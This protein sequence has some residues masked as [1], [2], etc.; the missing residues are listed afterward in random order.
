MTS[1][2]MNEPVV[3]SKRAHS[4][5]GAP[6]K[7][8]KAAQACLSCRKHKTRCE[9]LDGDNSGAQCHR[10]KVLSLSC[11]FEDGSGPPPGPS[12]A[13][14]HHPEIPPQSNIDRRSSVP[15]AKKILEVP[16]DDSRRHSKLWGESPSDTLPPF[17]A[18]PG[19]IDEVEL[20]HPE[21]LLP[22][23]QSP[24]GFLKLGGFESNMHL[25][26]LSTKID[27]TLLHVLGREQVKY[28][29]DIFEERYSPWL[30][31]Q[32]TNRNDGPLLRLAQCCVAS[33]HLEPSI[34]SIVAPQLYRFAEEVIF[35]QSFNPLPSTDA[36]HAMLVL[37][38]WEPVGDSP[39][40]ESRDW[41]TDSRNGGQYGHESSFKRSYELIEALDKAR[42][43]FALNS[44]ESMLCAGTGREPI[45]DCQSLTYEALDTTYST[46]S[47]I[48]DV[49]LSLVCQLFATT[50]QGFS[51]RLRSVDELGVFYKEVLDCLVHMDVIER[52]IAPLPVL[53]EH[54]VF[55]FRILHIYYQ[56]CRLLILV[57]ALMETKLTLTKSDSHNPWFLV[58]E[59]NGVN[60]AQCW[61]HQALVI[62]EAIL[63]TT[64][65][66]LEPALMSTAPDSVFS[67]ITFATI[68]VI[69]SKWSV[70]ENAG[71]Q[72]P[73]SSDSILTRTIEKLSL[74]ACSPDHFAAKCARVIESGVL[75][76]KRKIERSQTEM[77]EFSKP[78]VR[79]FTTSTRA[80]VSSASASRSA[81]VSSGMGTGGYANREPGC[82]QY[83]R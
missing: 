70:L 25:R 28:L 51:I 53:V 55:Y 34:R 38:L 81:S 36:I 75:S 71:Q 4:P 6:T 65:S 1:R 48:R 14:A 24:W 40:K 45:S 52:L 68:F 69:L 33:R 20:L 74:V 49:R 5:R 37:S 63:I 67:M 31:L 11:S 23:K 56:S 77:K 82:G 29:V 78:V 3:G 61:G 43:W 64:I 76:F 66:Q 57:H 19:D 8:A 59:H 21:R 17:R 10:C 80:D 39:P 15:L 46:I 13:R 18:P 32:P 22:E 58:A 16:I 62:S 50:H 26:V 7:R 12:S 35:K 42:L 73:G 83:G 41:K 2:D 47:T 72:M 79:H 44:I 27:Q 30:N 9:M 54:E 60:L